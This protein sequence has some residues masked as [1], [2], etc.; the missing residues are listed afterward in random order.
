MARDSSGTY[1]RVSNSFSAPVVGTIISPVDASS[2]FDD[3]ATEI[4]DSYS[5]S[6]KGGMLS[7]GTAGAPAFTWSSDLN[8]GIFR[9]GADNLGI[10]A[11]GTKIIDVSTTAVGITGALTATSFNGLTVST[12][13]GTLT[14][15]NGKTATV[16]NTLTFAG[17]DG[18][19]VAFGAGGTVAYT[20]NNLSVFAATTS[21]QLAGVLSDETGSGAAVFAN[22]PTLVT[23]VLGAATGT[24]LQLSGLTASSA[25][26][27]DASK[28][29]VSVT[30]TGSGNNVL[31]T[32]PTLVTPVLGAAS[33]TSLSLSGLTAS[34][35][36]ATDGSKNL[37]SVTN[38][39]SGNNVL[40]TSPT[41]VTPTIGAAT[42]TSINK[43]AITAPATS[44][45]LAVADGKT[46]TVSNTLTF[47]GTDSTTITFQGTDTYVGRATTDTLTNKT[48]DTAGTGNS[49]KIA[50]TG[51]TAITGTGSVMLAASPTTT[52]TLTGAAANFS[53]TITFGTGTLTALAADASP[54]SANDY[55]LSYD[56][57]ASAFKKVLMGTV[58]G[59]VG[60]VTSWNGLLGA[61]VSSTPGAINNLG[62]AASVSASALTIAIKDASGNDPSAGSPVVIS[63]RNATATTGT[64]STLSITAAASIV[65]SS[66]S[67]L[68]SA[69]GTAFN[70]YIVGF[71]D[72]G[73]FRLGVMNASTTD[74]IYP[75]AATGI[76]SSTAEGGAGAADSAGVFYTGTAVSSKAF[77]VLGRFTYGATPLATAGTYATA[78]DAVELVSQDF[79][80]PGTVIQSVASP[81]GTL[82][83]GTTLIP[84]DNTIPQ[85]SEGDQYFSQAITPKSHANLLAVSSKISGAHSVASW[86]AAALFR[87][88]AA[89]AFATDRAFFGDGATGHLIIVEGTVLAGSTA[90]TTF[91]LRAGGINAGTFSIGGNSGVNYFGG[92]M[93]SYL[94]VVE[95]QG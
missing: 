1:T 27:T 63:F 83:T 18:S 40:A 86:A 55:L 78:P 74:I 47:A 95:V 61:V 79:K 35:A 12:S 36:V 28:N 69:N 11:G 80:Y 20:A 60:T 31:A 45:T 44:S 68:G 56:A 3:M 46:A 91:K 48:F 88:S 51:I 26:A 19:S 39:G 64:P 84:L 73:T 67:T 66:G 25:V 82:Q 13:T 37:V 6:I 92:T 5:R 89:D 85:S 4:T 49:F 34:S 14:V 24:S 15:A 8:T 70:I 16:S 9:I 75:L 42:A 29:L 33:G 30:N 77:V 58:V 81:D 65:V 21:A 87:D 59:S 43:M 72:A 94:R 10:A 22:T 52:G 76:A 17:T 32:S 90:G 53:G 50:G 57:S 71:N 38:T 2:F 41:L 93:K 7:N 62:L 54:D 23:P